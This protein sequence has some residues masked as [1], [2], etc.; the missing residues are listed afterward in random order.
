[1]HDSTTLDQG[2]FDWH[3]SSHSSD[4]S[5]NCVEVG[6]TPAGTIPVRDTKQG[7]QGPVLTFDPQAWNGFISGIKAG[8]FPV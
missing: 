2:G 5:G 6:S 4:Q 1:M 3:K 7:K 8:E